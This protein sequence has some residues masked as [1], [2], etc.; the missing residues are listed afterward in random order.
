[1]ANSASA[2]PGATTAKLVFLLLAMPWK[3]VMMPQTVPNSPTKGATEPTVARNRSRR[4]SRS[5]S[6][7]I[8]TSMTRSMRICT[9]ASGFAVFSMDRRH[10]RIAATNSAPIALGCF[11]DMAV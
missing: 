7:V 8:V 10:S 4:S 9:P 3:A 5:I 11:C 2:M 1:M 6:R